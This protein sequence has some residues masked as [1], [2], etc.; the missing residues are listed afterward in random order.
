[1]AEQPAPQ[2]QRSMQIRIDES[3]METT[4]ANTIRTSTTPEE[5]VLD[6]GLNMPQHQQSPEGGAPPV[7]V[8]AVNSRVVLNWMGAKRLAQT[9]ANLV[10]AYED[11]HGE[12][13]MEPRG[14]AQR[15]G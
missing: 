5:V 15:P 2:Q 8:F 6:F 10:R 1:M 13:P 3:H 7:M 9:M 4:Y 12:I 14:G 11:K